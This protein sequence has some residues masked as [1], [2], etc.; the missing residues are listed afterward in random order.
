[1]NISMSPMYIYP[2]QEGATVRWGISSINTGNLSSAIILCKYYEEGINQDGRIVKVNMGSILLCEI[3]ISYD[4]IIIFVGNATS[5]TKQFRHWWLQTSMHI[6]NG[7]VVCNLVP[8]NE[9]KIRFFFQHQIA[10]SVRFN[11][12]AWI[13]ML[14]FEIYCI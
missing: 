10:F 9:M 1:M 3:T 13:L 2:I 12:K 5:N 4:L 14:C 6:F 11:L 7:N 8:I